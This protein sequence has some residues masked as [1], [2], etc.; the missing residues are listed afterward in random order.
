MTPPRDPAPT[1]PF[2]PPWPGPATRR[3][4]RFALVALVLLVGW[5]AL[6]PQPPRALSTGWD[7]LNHAIAFAAL[8]AVACVGFASHGLAERSAAGPAVMGALLA[9]GVLIEWVQTHIPGRQGDAR[10][11]LAD[12]VGLALGTAIVWLV[13]AQ[14]RRWTR[15]N[16]S[17]AADASGPRSSA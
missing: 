5:L 1:L 6:V 15:K 14:V 2:A 10:D 16:A 8:G 13:R 11:V 7:K 17:I 3:A 12:V 9:Y 4:A